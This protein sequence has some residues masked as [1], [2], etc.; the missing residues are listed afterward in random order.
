MGHKGRNKRGFGTVQ[1]IHL[2]G[3]QC[4]DVAREEAGGMEVGDFSARGR[5]LGFKPKILR[6]F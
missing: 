4:G 2:A 5:G 3:K 1:N 6:R